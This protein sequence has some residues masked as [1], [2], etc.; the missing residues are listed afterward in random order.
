V[1][2]VFD[3]GDGIKVFVILFKKIPPPPNLLKNLL[4][5]KPKETTIEEGM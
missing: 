2:F 3:L 5:F 4:L 1:E